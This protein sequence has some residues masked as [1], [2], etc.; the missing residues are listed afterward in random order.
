MTFFLCCSYYLFFLSCFPTGALVLAQLPFL[1][2]TRGK[3]SWLKKGLAVTNMRKKKE[4]SDFKN[5]A[6]FTCCERHTPPP[7]PILSTFC[8]TLV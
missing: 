1:F 4:R 2:T 6:S 3:G 8:W 7:T 5:D